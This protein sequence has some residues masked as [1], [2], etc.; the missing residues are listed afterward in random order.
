MG[1]RFPDAEEVGGSKPPAPTRFTFQ[2]MRISVGFAVVGLPQ[3]LVPGEAF[4]HLAQDFIR[5][6]KLPGHPP[7]MGF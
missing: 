4:L 6:A 5:P 2:A 1:E 3:R 7:I